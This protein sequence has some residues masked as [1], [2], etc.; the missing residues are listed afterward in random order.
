[1]TLRGCLTSALV[2]SRRGPACRR[3]LIACTIGGSVP[4]GIARVAPG[5][6]PGAGTA[7]G[8]DGKPPSINRVSS[9]S[10]CGGTVALD[11]TGIGALVGAATLTGGGTDVGGGV[12]VGAT[13][14]VIGASVPGMLYAFVSPPVTSPRIGVG[15]CC[16]FID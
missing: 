10:N 6:A 11:G 8:R 15:G 7:T 5:G 16:I 4:I 9:S 3:A 1:A 13:V 2:N 14:G 12:R